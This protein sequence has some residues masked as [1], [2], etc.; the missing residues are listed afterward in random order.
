MPKN[1]VKDGLLNIRQPLTYMTAYEFEYVNALNIAA[2]FTQV[3]VVFQFGRE[4]RVS[5][6]FSNPVFIPN[7]RNFFAECLPFC[8]RKLIGEQCEGAEIGHRNRQTGFPLCYTCI[9]YFD[10]R[11]QDC[12]VRLTS[13]DSFFLQIERN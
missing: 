13:Y 7:L 4:P 8:R 10:I 6:M 11:S 5:L 9:L 12:T 2:L 1:S 3:S